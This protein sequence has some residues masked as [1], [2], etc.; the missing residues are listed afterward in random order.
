MGLIESLCMLF[1]LGTFCHG[2]VLLEDETIS[3][4]QDYDL[5]ILNLRDG[6]RNDG[7]PDYDPEYFQLREDGRNDGEPDYDPETLSVRSYE[8]DDVLQVPDSVWQNEANQTHQ[9]RYLM[10]FPEDYKG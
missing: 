3:L 8:E 4:A 10:L 6:G 9:R 2:N 1:L 7:E 5:D